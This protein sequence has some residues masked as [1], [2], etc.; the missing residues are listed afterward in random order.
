[1]DEL[2]AE[3]AAIGDQISATTLL[4]SPAEL[5]AGSDRRRRQRRLAGGG[6]FLA[7]AA[8][9]ALAQAP[10]GSTP[11]PRGAAVDHP[12]ASTPPS[13]TPATTDRSAILNGRHA[14]RLRVFTSWDPTDLYLAAMPGD[15]DRVFY[16][17]ADRSD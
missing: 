13:A 5:R 7:V 17:D 8:V 15:N 10:S 4:A 12:A 14:V 1:M 3:L 2:D 16:R 6:A 9:A 11:P